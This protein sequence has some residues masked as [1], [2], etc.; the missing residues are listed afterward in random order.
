M[1]GY[2]L[3]TKVKHSDRT[4][5]FEDPTTDR[6]S[7]NPGLQDI[8]YEYLVYEHGPRLYVTIRYFGTHWRSPTDPSSYWTYDHRRAYTYTHTRWSYGDEST[9]THWTPKR[10]RSS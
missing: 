1:D 6:V 2:G 8:V 7:R 10:R 3:I 4:S 5:H 9:L